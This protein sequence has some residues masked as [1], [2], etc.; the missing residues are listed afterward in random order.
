[1]SYQH[2]EFYPLNKAKTPKGEITQQKLLEAAEE[3]F[4][5]KGYYNTSVVEITQKA[6]VSQGT[7]YVY[8][9]GKQEIFRQLV[10]MLNHTIRQEIQIAITGIED[11]RSRERIG[12]KTFFSFVRRHRNL[13]KIVLE[14][15]WV[16]DE[17]CQWYFKTF[18]QGYI[19]G[20]QGAMNKGELR[21]LDPETLAYCLMGI[22][23]E[24]SKRWVL[25]ED[26]EIP[27]HVFE[28]MLEFI[29]HGMLNDTE[30]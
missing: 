30:E 10:I 7:F 26:R 14:A 28:N 20:L 22:T 24:V 4:G 2:N 27:E 18:A 12:Y 5:R 19:K 3:I 23:I 25:W 21:R 17:I 15:Q 29:F 16:D 1:M 8:F 6:G 13:Y 11:R 9:S